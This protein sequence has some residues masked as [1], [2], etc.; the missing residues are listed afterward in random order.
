MRIRFAAAAAAMLST[1]VMTPLHAEVAN[2][3]DTLALASRIENNSFDRAELM[4]GN[5]IQFWQP[6]FDTLII[7]T[8]EGEL[9]SNLAT[10]WSYND[11]G[12]VLMLMLRE[13]V[14]F[15]DGTPFNAEAVKA[16]LEYLAA[17]NGQNS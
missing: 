10:E 15:T 3:A 14:S 16:N 9:V 5:Q 8:P 12:T 7:E 1:T 13:G 4:L 2:D 6:V 17:G 11:D